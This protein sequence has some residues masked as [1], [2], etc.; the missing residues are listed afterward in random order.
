MSEEISDESDPQPPYG[1]VVVFRAFAFLEKLIPWAFATAIVYLL[2]PFL[3]T[4]AGKETLADFRIEMITGKALIHWPICF[5]IGAVGVIYGW[6]QFSLRKKNIALL[7]GQARKFEESVDP[8]RTSS[9]LTKKG[10]TN[11]EDK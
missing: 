8:E 10:D 7:E 11:P 9:Q 2:S 4:L 6:R 5:S 3:I 1:V